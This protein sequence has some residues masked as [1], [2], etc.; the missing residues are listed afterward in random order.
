MA[1]GEVTGRKPGSKEPAA[2]R[3]SGPP[4]PRLAFTVKEFCGA[5]RISEDMFWKMRRDGW[6]PKLMRVGTKVLISVAAAEQWQKGRE[7]AAARD[8]PLDYVKVEA[9][10]RAPR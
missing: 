4:V 9:T 8:L 1:C 5:F 7:A 6:A 10:R 2:A 3:E